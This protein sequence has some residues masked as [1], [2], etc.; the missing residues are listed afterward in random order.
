MCRYSCCKSTNV[1]K[2]DGTVDVKEFAYKDRAVSVLNAERGVMGP[3]SLFASIPKRN[4]FDRLPIER[5]IVP[6]NEFVD[7]RR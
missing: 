3:R 5:G 2:E 7:K 1:T 6:V 4:N